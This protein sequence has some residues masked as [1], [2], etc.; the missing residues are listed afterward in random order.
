MS[1]VGLPVCRYAGT[2]DPQAAERMCCV[3]AAAA[4]AGIGALTVLV[5]GVRLLSKRPPWSGFMAFLFV[6]LA[7]AAI[8]AVSVW[9]G[10]CGGSTMPCRTGTLPGVWLVGGFQCLLSLACGWGFR[11]RGS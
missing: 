2:L 5:A 3:R 10:L 11:K 9:P 4:L 8:A 6:A 1:F 7:L